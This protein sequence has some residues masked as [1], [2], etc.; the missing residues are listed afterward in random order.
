M[1]VNLQYA[2]IFGKGDGS[3]W[4]D[5]EIELTA[6][7]E[8]A[9]NN[10]IEN[11][12]PLEDVVELEGALSRAREEIESCEIGSFICS[13]DEYVLEIQGENEMDLDELN[14][15]VANRDPH[16][17]EFFGLTDAS[18]DELEEWDAYELDEVPTV[19]EFV[20]NFEPES[21]FDCGWELRV[22][23]VDPNGEY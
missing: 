3:D 23:F 10:A 16:A 11:G 2:V 20:E 9:Y 7:E 8:I 18:E 19:Y 17:L 1:V 13:G 14:E 21:P 15:L 22:M 12:I 6:E 4:I 5:W